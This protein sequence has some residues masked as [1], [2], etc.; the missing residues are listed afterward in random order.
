MAKEISDEY[1]EELHEAFLMF[2][3]NRDGSIS[4]QELSQILQNLNQ[5]ATMD[6]INEMIKQVDVDGD[7]EIG[8]CLHTVNT[9]TVT[10]FDEFVQ[11]M[12]NAKCSTEEEMKQ[13]FDV[14]DADGNGYIDKSE[15]GEVLKQLGEEVCFVGFSCSLCS[16]GR[17]TTQ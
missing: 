3:K 8:T 2:D 17:G 10:D 16:G 11:M 4:V 7:G 13:A 14:F 5:G 12:A 15:L 6:E 9:K 1:R